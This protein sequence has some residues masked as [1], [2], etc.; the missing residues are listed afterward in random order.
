MAEGAEGCSRGSLR[1]EARSY[2]ACSDEGGERRRERTRRTYTNDGKSPLEIVLRG[3]R[4]RLLFVT[5]P[6]DLRSHLCAH[7]YTL[8]LFFCLF[9]RSRVRGLQRGFARHRCAMSRGNVR[10]VRSVRVKNVAEWRPVR[11]WR[12]TIARRKLRVIFPLRFTCPACFRVLW[13]S[14]EALSV[15]WNDRGYRCGRCQGWD[16]SGDDG[17][18]TFAGTRRRICNVNFGGMLGSG[19]IGFKEFSIFLF[20]GNFGEKFEGEVG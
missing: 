4:N 15:F 7:T 19:W 16:V 20:D 11:G 2:V 9:V 14:K 18:N 8:F 10:R 17:R 13:W 6:S 3:R 12:S 5:F 1:R